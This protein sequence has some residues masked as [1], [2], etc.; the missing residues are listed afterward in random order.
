MSKLPR[1]PFDT[2]VVENIPDSTYID[3][4][5]ASSDRNYNQQIVRR[6]M[7]VTA[8]RYA[9]HTARN[10]H[11]VGM[12]AENGR[13]VD[14]ATHCSGPDASSDSESFPLAG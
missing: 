1:L 6:H 9:Q 13:M 5:P 7:A 11:G 2:S 14:G 10:A 8:E 4:L 3:A 12:R